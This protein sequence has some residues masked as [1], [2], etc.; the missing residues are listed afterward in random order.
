M[1]L[2]SNIRKIRELRN[3]TQEYV[4]FELHLS[5]A[6]YSKLENGRTKISVNRLLQLAAILSVSLDDMVNFD[7]KALLAGSARSSAGGEE[8]R[9]SI[10]LPSAAEMLAAT[11][12]RLE[13]ENSYLKKMVGHS[14][15]PAKKSMA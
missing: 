3:F 9:Q 2:A 11:V 10:P 7:E 4:A 6:S 13:Q 8:S 5:Q 1:M 12:Q 15:N 14:V